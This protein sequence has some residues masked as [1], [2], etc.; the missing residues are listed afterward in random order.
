VTNVNAHGRTLGIRACAAGHLLTEE[1]QPLG[2]CAGPP[3]FAPNE[4]PSVRRPSGGSRENLGG[5][6]ADPTYLVDIMVVASDQSRAVYGSYNAFIADSFAMI[7]DANF[8]VSASGGGWSY[9]LCAAPWT[10]IAGYNERGN[11][12][13]DLSELTYAI[14][15]MEDGYTTVDSTTDAVQ[16]QRNDYRP[17]LIAMIVESGGTGVG[18]RPPS[19]QIGSGYSV[20]LR[21]AAISNGTFA[22]EIGHNLCACH[23]ATSSAPQCAS[24][25]TPTPRGMSA[26]ADVPDGICG[27]CEDTE[28]Y[29]TMAYQSDGSVSHHIR[30]QR[31][32]I[33]GLTATL[34]GSFGSDTV[35][36][37]DGESQSLLTQ[38]AARVL[39][40]NFNV[41][42]TQI[43]AIPGVGGAHNGTWQEPAATIKAASQLVG[44]TPEQAIVRARG[45]T[46]GETAANG[47]PVVINSA[48]TIVPDQGV[49][50]LQ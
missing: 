36:L 40:S 8:R 25:Y 2:E 17:D 19:P 23:N 24:P 7:A 33:M 35:D 15:T 49:V 3:A 12:A 31:Y 39:A 38:N 21:S 9:R 41:A 50:V 26:T 5:P 14:G 48:C 20:S 37:W 47:G 10:L 30:V 29:T 18:W 32:S 6:G 22:H 27:G 1:G 34:N 46:Y 16:A 13:H 45:G 42:V 28:F 43:W 4:P 11:I 44:G